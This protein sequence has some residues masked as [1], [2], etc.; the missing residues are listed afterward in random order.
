[1]SKLILGMLLLIGLLSLV[2]CGSEDEA[3][4]PPGQTPSTDTAG[5][6]ADYP[7]GDPTGDPTSPSETAGQSNAPMPSEAMILAGGEHWSA[8][9]GGDFISVNIKPGNDYWI[10]P[11]DDAPAT[12]ATDRPGVLVVR[13]HAQL[14][15]GG[16]AATGGTVYGVL[17]GGN[18]TSKINLRVASQE[19]GSTAESGIL[20]LR[21]EPWKADASGDIIVSLS[22][23]GDPATMSNVIRLKTAR[24]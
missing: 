2:G 6:S 16:R 8:F 5:N 20:T 23:P 24:P 18:E 14:R 9:P 13:L 3:P 21:F 15:P 22:R 1:M 10:W 19:L 7:S 17:L 4:I 12:L 11:V